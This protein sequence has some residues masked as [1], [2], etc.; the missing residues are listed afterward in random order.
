MKP[1][2][3]LIAIFTPGEVGWVIVLSLFL[4]DILRESL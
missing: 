1:L 2:L 3:I 4:I